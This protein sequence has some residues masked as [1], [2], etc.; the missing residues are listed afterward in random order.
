MFEHSNIH[1]MKK[2]LF[3]T[4]LVVHALLG[5]SQQPGTHLLWQIGKADNSVADLTGSPDRGDKFGKDGVFIVGRSNEKQD[6][7]WAHPGPDDGWAG[8][9][10]HS[11]YILFGVKDFSGA[12]SCRL[13]VRLMDMH[14]ATRDRLSIHINGREYTKVLPRG[15]GEGIYGDFS[16]AKP[17]EFTIGFP[18]DL[19]IKGDNSISITNTSGSWFVYDWLGLEAPAG[20]VA[21]PVTSNVFISAAKGLPFIA[22]GER[23]AYQPA[24][25]SLLNTGGEGRLTLK[26]QGMENQVLDLATGSQQLDFRTPVVTKDSSLVV[27]IEQDDRSIGERTLALQPVT[28]RTIY[29]LPHSHND[30]GYT[31]IQT[32]VEWKQIDNLLKGIE[33]ARK[34][35][36]YPAGARFVWNLEGTYVAD[37]FLQ[38]MTPQQKD[39]FLQAVKDGGVAL[40]GMYLNTLTGLCR[41][42]ELLRLFK[43]STELEKR[44]GVKVDAAMI[45]DVPGY[46]WGT[47]QAMAQAGIKYFSAAPNY[48]DRIGDILPSWENKPFY[49][50]SQSGKEKLLVWIPYKGY[51][52]S[53]GV[54][55]LS[56]EFVASYTDALKKVAYPYGITYI[57]W[58]GHGDNAVP[59]LAISD[60]VKNWNEKYIAPRFIIS[61]TSTA[62]RAF[63]AA[64]GGKL[65]VVQG[66][67]TGY[68]EDGAASSASETAEN[69]TSSSRLSQA[70]AMWAMTAP[71]KFPAAQF[72]DA[73]HH[74]LLYSEHTWG[75]DESVTR[76]LSQKTKEQ[77]DIKKS[78]A[79]SAGAQS[80]SLLA[81]AITQSGDSGDAVMQT[82]NSRHDVMHTGN[83]GDANLHT[84]NSRN[85]I[86][87]FNTNSWTRTNLVLVPA[88]LSTAGDIVQD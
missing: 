49:W 31:E 26:I 34:T 12:D 70:E 33:Y 40:N 62:F 18:A 24:Q 10:Q 87:V 37:L 28:L 39:D 32:K 69:R 74:V 58:S 72:N 81:G 45:S 78:Y 15:S 29:M 71:D 9:R 19:L 51:A 21:Q 16:K 73:W 59:E 66:D 8:N 6:W 42:E 3:L 63:E 85:A 80:K 25:L 41:P 60:F 7:P 17:Y 57:R 44:T 14:Q 79:D 61:S 4:V 27:K 64:Y 88:A 43:F 83:S 75:A 30:I 53:H 50:L 20:I 46:T 35:K 13:R 36:D 2:C 1:A 67:W 23:G 5:V 84:S 38:R 52:L 76:P 54:P 22:R 65:P 47:V 56:A 86:D 68:W 82:G 11:F 55:H 48:F 77:W